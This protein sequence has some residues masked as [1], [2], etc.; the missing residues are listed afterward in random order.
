MDES[1]IS[2]LSSKAILIV[3]TGSLA[4]YLQETFA[5]QK[6]QQ[7][8]LAWESPNI[9]SWREAC[10]RAWLFNQSKSFE[11]DTLISPQQARLLWTKVV[12]ETARS[13]SELTLLNVPQT[14][15]ACMRSHR[16][17][18]DWRC[19]DERL[20]DEHIE[21]LNQFIEWRTRYLSLL[22]NRDFADDAVLQN[23][24]LDAADK[25]DFEWP[26]ERTIWYAYDLLTATQRDF[27]RSI[28]RAGSAVI[29]GGPRQLN[30]QSTYVRYEDADKEIYA[31]FQSAR[32]QLDLK[33][34]LKIGIVIPDLQHR[35]AKV[36]Q[37][38]HDIFY[39][40]QT[41]LNSEGNQLVYRFSL[42]K[43]MIDIPAIEAALC[44]LSL[45][46]NN[47]TVD[48]F[49]FLLNSNYL[50][51]NRI[52]SRLV[53]HFAKWLSEKRFMR[54]VIS[55]CPGLFQEF[56]E[57]YKENASYAGSSSEQRLVEL[58]EALAQSIQHLQ[59]ELQSQFIESGFKSL[60]FDRW[61]DVFK[62]WLEAWG[63]SSSRLET[64]SMSSTSQLS[65]RWDTV[66]QDYST[67][68][69]VQHSTGLNGALSH[70][71]QLL[72][73]AVYLP[74]SASSPIYVSGLLEALGRETD[75]CFLTGMT[76]DF[77]PPSRPDSF[78]PNH[79]LIST[80]L[81]DAS[82]QLSSMQS[83]KVIGGL[84]SACKAIE[85]SFSLYS[86][87]LDEVVNGPSPLFLAQFSDSQ[88]AK[89]EQSVNLEGELEYFVDT[90]G[91]AWSS[92]SKAR[93]GS[94]IFKNQSHCP[95]KAF[96]TH[97]LP[98]EVK[99]E[100]DFGLN[101]L[102]RGNLIH[103]MMELVWGRLPSQS[104]LLKLDQSQQETMLESCYQ[105]LLLHSSVTLNDTLQCLFKLEKNRVFELVAEW[106]DVERKRPCDF[107]VVERE[108]RYTGEWA[109]IRFDYIVDRVDVTDSGNSVLVDY[110]TSKVNRADWHG[111]RLKEPQLPLY[112][113]ARDATKATELSGLAFAQL[114]RGECKYVELADVGILAVESHKTKKYQEQWQ[115]SIDTW[116]DQLTRLA[117][118]FLAGQAVVDPIDETVCQYCKLDSVCRI[119]Q[120]KMQASDPASQAGASE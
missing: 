92:Q 110:K 52:D 40:N 22:R 116:P 34:D 95:F 75:L 55:K 117:E 38:A 44:A 104:A 54:L 120:L 50:L 119:S 94:A 41:L 72:I 80:G 71:R 89:S 111:D 79:L 64:E 113:L 11:F 32:R 1:S 84:I 35:Y 46:K 88:L 12:D 19:T 66:L 90:K 108:A 6:I 59:E 25:V 2:Q 101:S 43:P 29:E 4:T 114:R 97:Q 98:F 87:S 36:Q 56:L 91:P 85:V 49:Q 105:E 39:P 74:K 51:P 9:V 13:N 7:G 58:F 10:R 42:G 67:L 15:K 37:I 61:V 28:E 81:P 100:S 102:D 16:L 31:V 103:K 93:G 18:S 20:L 53:G 23:A 78:I 14:V 21:D 106:L 45:L 109:G 76:Q 30:E 69:T 96:V 115:Q 8:R 24:I 86:S 70:L 83:Q 26:F 63:W 99:P 5:D 57:E 82:P 73:E 77:P 33:P 65:N 48:D 17:L 27:S 112:V 3:P 118:D 62:Q 68:N 107:S 47:S 60:R